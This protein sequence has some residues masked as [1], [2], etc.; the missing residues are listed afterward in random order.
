MDHGKTALVA[1]RGPSVV[2]LAAGGRL[3]RD[4]DDDG[5]GL[6]AVARDL[7]VR[8]CVS[9][10]YRNLRHDLDEFISPVDFYALN[11]CSNIQFTV[12]RR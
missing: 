4:S 12:E 9:R 6:S 11:K 10:R 7:C 1:R 8:V 5:N 3:T 2:L